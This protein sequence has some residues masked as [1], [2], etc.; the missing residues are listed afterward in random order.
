MIYVVINNKSKQF[1]VVKLTN[2]QVHLNKKEC[3]GKVNLFQ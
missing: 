1:D 3:R 2:V